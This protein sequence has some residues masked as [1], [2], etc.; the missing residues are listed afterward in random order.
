MIINNSIQQRAGQIAG[1]SFTFQFF[2]CFALRTQ[3]T[4]GNR[5]LCNAEWLTAATFTGYHRRSDLAVSPDTLGRWHSAEIHNTHVT[6][7]YSTGKLC[8]L[9]G[10]ASSL[11]FTFNLAFCWAKV[12]SKY[13]L[14]SK[15]KVVSLS[16]SLRP[17]FAS[18]VW[19]IGLAKDLDQS[20]SLST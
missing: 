10:F 15:S 6:I 12:R 13:R 19:A 14:K 8:V 4:G 11:T 17:N 18:L 2:R 20:F 16:Q 3:H 7:H 1:N 5:W 9:V